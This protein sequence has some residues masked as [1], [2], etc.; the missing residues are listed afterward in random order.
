MATHDI[1][2]LEAQGTLFASRRGEI[3]AGIYEAIRSCFAHW[4]AL[5]NFD[6]EAAFK[7]YLDEAFE[8]PDRLGFDLATMRLI[9][10][11]R[12]GHTAFADEWLWREHGAPIGFNATHD[13]AGWRV[14][15]SAYSDI[16][17]GTRLV[18][19]DDQ[20]I[21]EVASK[22]L[23]FVSG[24]SV[25]EQR[26]R[27]FSKPFLF[28]PSFEIMTGD[29]SKR[30]INRGTELPEDGAATTGRW[31]EDER[32]L[33]TI[34]SFA[35]PHFE[36]DA[37]ELMKPLSDTV[38]LVID[39]RGNSGGHTPNELVAALM[40]TRYR[41][42]NHV[43]PASNALARAQGEPAYLVA[44]EAKWI[45]PLDGAFKGKLTILI[46]SR[47]FSAAEDFVARFKDNKRAEI[48]GETTGGSS[49]QPYIR[50]LGDGIRL[51]VSAKRQIF[52]NG[53][54]FEGLGIEPDT[55]TKWPP[56]ADFGMLPI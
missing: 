23:V 21:D 30:Q 45:Q 4:E 22:L 12:N 5:P 43:T 54:S 36:A 3:A 8:A 19:I 42:W 24:S 51:W 34:P 52:P 14:T 56:G 10:N 2:Q 37:I 32:Y 7:D 29:G 38:H 1:D 28:P 6:F 26:N 53:S 20:P 27:L 46:D 44:S 49:G 35:Q 9:A 50:D 13:E 55:T 25:R 31:L 17:P 11:L 48:V 15:K 39:V 33:L 40:P 41:F 16:A 18:R 47:T